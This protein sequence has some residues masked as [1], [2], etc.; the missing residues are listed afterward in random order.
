MFKNSLRGYYLYVLNSYICAMI[1][2][3]KYRIY[4]NKVQ[5]ELIN[6]HIG[7]CRFVFNLALE[8]KNYAYASHRKKLTCFDL[9][10]QLP[11]LKKECE[12]L[13]EIDSQ[14]LQQSV[15]NLDKAFTA[16]FKG[17]AAFPNFK[18][19]KKGIQSF[20]NPHGNHVE[21]KEGKLYQPK[22]K[23]G[24]KIVIDR[25]F[26]GD[27]KSTTISRTPTGKYF[28]SILTDNHKELPKKK[29][30][31][32]ST[33]VGIDLGLTHFI[34]TSEGVKVD[35][36]KHL[37]KSMLHLKYLQRQASKKVNGSKNRKKANLKVA[38]C[39]EKI[40]NQRKDF[41]HKLSNEITN[42]FDTLCFEDLNITGMTK[43]HKL[44]GAIADV[45]WGEFVRQVEYKSEWKGKT[46]LKIPTFEPSTKLCHVCGAVN[47]TLTLKDREWVCANCETVHDRDINAAKVI[48]QYCINNSGGGLH[49]PKRGEQPKT[50][51]GVL[52]HENKSIGACP[53]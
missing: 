28:V 35:N 19:K 6:K 5:A 11:D 31:K 38:L 41:L 23:D 46:I 15:I 1:K 49:L 18:S 13:N 12:W 37:R 16:F 22:F 39:H 2:G 3:N 45:S 9:M 10:N 53:K 43:N 44:A 17:H 30:I 42:Q 25:Q 51:V 52:N 40:T 29:P 14:A 26:T 32:E 7:A 47:H 20:R 8:T 36:P 50:L 48:K 34:I 24:I 4:P 21:V 27:I 33:S